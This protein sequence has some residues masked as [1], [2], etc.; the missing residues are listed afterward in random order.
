MTYWKKKKPQMVSAPTTVMIAAAASGGF[1]RASVRQ[2][3]IYRS[4]CPLTSFNTARHARLQ[5]EAPRSRRCRVVPL[6]GLEPAR[7]STPDFESG[8]STNSAR[9]ALLRVGARTIAAHKQGSTATAGEF[10][11]PDMALSRPSRRAYDPRQHS[12]SSGERDERRSPQHVAAQIPQ[13]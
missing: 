5:D 1:L 13:G 3:F 6:A 12:H 10:L 7:I 8:A 4:T 9:G 2:S 11:R